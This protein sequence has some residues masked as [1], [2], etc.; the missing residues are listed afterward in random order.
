MDDLIKWEVDFS[1]PYNDFDISLDPNSAREMI[2]LKIPL[3]VQERMNEFG[4]ESLKNQ[5]LSMINHI[6]FIGILLL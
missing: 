1:K 2:S 5:G 6:S 4:K 3:W